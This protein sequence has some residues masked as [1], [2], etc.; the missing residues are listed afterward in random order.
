MH[1]F[2]WS[3][4]RRAAV[5]I[6]ACACLAAVIVVT[7]DEATS[8]AGMRVAR[9][10]AMGPLLACLGVLAVCSHARLRG[11]IGALEA[12]GMPP[13]EASRGAAVAGW[14]FS[15]VTLALLA[16]PWVDPESLFPKFSPPID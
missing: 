11:E 5:V 14:A 3:L 16:L 12:L 8:T 4:A 1:P 13:W 10:A 2:A 15:A 7:T 6:A 9:L